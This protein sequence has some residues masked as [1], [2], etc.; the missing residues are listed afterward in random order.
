METRAPYVVIGI[1]VLAVIA[2]AFGF[3]YWFQH[4]GGLGQ[5]A[6][7]QVRFDQPV[8]GLALGSAVLFNGIRVG[9]VTQ[10]QLY[11]D[12]P[13]RLT[14]WISVDATTPVRADT[15]I[16]VDQ[17]V[18]TGTAAIS[19]RGGATSAPRLVARNGEPPILIAERSIGQD[20]TRAARDTLRDVRQILSDNAEPLRTAISSLSTFADMLARNSD[21]LE[22]VIAGLERLTGGG[23]PKQPPA[24]YDLAAPVSFPPLDPIGPGHL[25]VPDPAAVLVFDSQKILV[26]SDGGTLSGMENAQ[27]ADNLPKLM[28]AKIIQGF[29]NARQTRAVSRPIDDLAGGSRLLLEIRRFEL[30]GAAPPM[31]VVEFAARLVDDGGKVID[32]RMFRSTATAKSQATADA[33][34]ALNEAFTGTARELV[35]W[36]V[37]LMGNTTSPPP[38]QAPVD[39]ARPADAGAGARS[40]QPK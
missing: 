26:R 30:T 10:L 17:Q 34:A 29:E 5:R 28:Q 3:V 35:L 37:E 38:K 13:E 8:A 12:E 11:P 24:V 16:D 9:E 22:G 2:G 32:A 40:D 23:A 36:S 4:A 33:V 19:L 39:E 15:R 21:R 1:F 18:L 20:L 31:A 7:Y 6:I 14:A 25:S 27:W